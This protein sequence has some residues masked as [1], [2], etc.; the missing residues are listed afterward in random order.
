MLT[1]RCAAPSP[2]CLLLVQDLL[3]LKGQI[4]AAHRRTESVTLLIAEG[5]F[6]VPRHPVG[7]CGR[8]GDP[9]RMGMPLAH[10]PDVEI[11]RTKRMAHWLIQWA[12]STT[13]VRTG[14]A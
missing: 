12:S 11:V 2:Q 10:D 8:E 13:M 1:R 7:G 6:N 9:I 4:A 5:L 3:Y 14:M